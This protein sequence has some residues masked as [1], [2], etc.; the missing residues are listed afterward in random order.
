MLDAPLLL[1][2]GW[3]GLCDTLVFVDAPRPLRMARAVGRGWREEEFAAREGVQ[4]SLDSKRA[5]ADVIID[6]SGSPESTRA[7][8]ERFWHTLVG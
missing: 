3:D 5:R 7:Q 8:V 6:N 1:E 4:K 2:A